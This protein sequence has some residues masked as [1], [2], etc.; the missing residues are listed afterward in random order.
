LTRPLMGDPGFLAACVRVQLSPISYI[1]RE[2]YVSGEIDNLMGGN[3]GHQ[4]KDQ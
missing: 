2:T 1:D 4:K 3:D